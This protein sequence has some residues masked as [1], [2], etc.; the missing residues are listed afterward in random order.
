[1]LWREPIVLFL[2]IYV[3]FVYGILYLLL[4]A[5]P[6]AF[7]N[8]GWRETIAT[9]PFLSIIIGCFVAAAIIIGFN[10]YYQREM[11]RNSGRPVPRARL[12]PM[13]IGG[14]IFPIG[15]FIF[16]WSAD[17]NHGH[18]FWLVPCIGLA[19]VG[20]GILLIFL[21][22]LNYL[23]DVY[24]MYSASAIAANTMVRSLLAAVFPLVA[25]YMFHNMGVN[26]ASTLLGLLA[27]IMA[28]VPI[29]FYY[30]DEKLRNS[31]KYSITPGEKPKH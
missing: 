26:W 17:I 15:F 29:M 14:F 7:T 16:A 8:R 19:C 22:A 5:I 27:L 21:Q 12:P 9:L 18:V 31:S 4:S 13:I 30:F 6:I 23:I 2:T 1:M 11:E 3:S 28:P 25:T 20:C 10:P 24:L